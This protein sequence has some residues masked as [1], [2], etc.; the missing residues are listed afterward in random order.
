MQKILNDSETSDLKIQIKY[1]L[2]IVMFSIEKIKVNGKMYMG[3]ADLGQ[4]S[5]NADSYC[6]IVN[7][8]ST[9]GIVD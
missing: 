9:I 3:S 6:L 8:Q 1:I 5:N 4:V 2:K 7:F